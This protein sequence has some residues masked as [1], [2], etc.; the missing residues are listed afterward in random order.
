MTME[1]EVA[2]NEQAAY[3]HSNGQHNLPANGRLSAQQVAF[4]DREGYLL[5]DKPVLKQDQFDR[6][7]AIFEENLARYGEDDLDTIH[8]RDDRLFEFLFSDEVLDLV[9]PIIGGDIG[10]WSSHFITKSPRVGKATPWHEDSAYWNGRIS[11]MAN[12]ITVW[13]AIDEA[14]PENGCMKV[15]PGTHHNGFSEYE[16]VDASKNIFGSQIKADQFDADKAV[17]FSLKP[18]HCSLHEARIIHGADAN[19]SDKRR[20]GYTMRYFPTT[21]QVY[22]EKWPGHKI[23]LARGRDIA[24]NKFENTVPGKP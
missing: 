11:T 19:T 7:T 18:N 5:F 22:P 9:E 4:Y 23:W 1:I 2:A 14:T 17:Y 10:L 3:R 8:F 6:L 20:C 21:S 24:G 13:L 16:V 12:I 15:I